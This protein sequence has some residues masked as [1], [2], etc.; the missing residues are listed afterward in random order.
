MKKTL[1]LTTIVLLSFQTYAAKSKVKK[2]SRTIVCEQLIQQAEDICT[3]SM[4]AEQEQ[5][6]IENGIEQDQCVM[7][8]DFN[9]GKQICVYDGELP[10]LI[11]NYN[12]STGKNLNCDDL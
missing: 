11:K 6:A 5:F 9:E 3:E 8:G 4:C 12:K 10:E 1:L 7:D 2:D